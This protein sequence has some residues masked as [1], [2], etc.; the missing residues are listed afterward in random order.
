MHLR[1]GKVYF[2][3]SIYTYNYS[4]GIEPCPVD[5]D[6]FTCPWLGIYG[7]G[8]SNEKWGRHWHVPLCTHPLSSNFA[9]AW[10]AYRCPWGVTERFCKDVGTVSNPRKCQA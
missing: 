5:I 6:F 7:R 2:L 10:H 9:C 1:T 3:F 4:N 8:D